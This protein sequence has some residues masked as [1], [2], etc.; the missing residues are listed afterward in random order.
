MSL[1]PNLTQSS[2]GD[3]NS[4]ARY[5]DGSRLG[6]PAVIQAGT[7]LSDSLAR[8]YQARLANALVTTLRSAQ[9]QWSVNWT[10]DA[11]EVEVP[12][13]VAPLSPLGQQ[14]FVFEIEKTLSVLARTASTVGQSIAQEAKEAIED[15]MKAIRLE[16]VF[17]HRLTGTD[18]FPEGAREL[19]KALK[20]PDESNYK[21][22]I[23][24]LVK[25]VKD[26]TEHEQPRTARQWETITRVLDDTFASAI[27][28]IPNS[29]LKTLV[30]EATSAER[31]KQRIL[32]DIFQYQ[33][34]NDKHVHITVFV[35]SLLFPGGQ[36]TTRAS[37]RVRADA[38]VNVPGAKESTTSQIGLAM[39]IDDEDAQV[40]FL[41]L[42]LSEIREAVLRHITREG[43]RKAREK[44]AESQTHIVDTLKGV[45]FKL[46]QTRASVATE[47]LTTIFLHAIDTLKRLRLQTSASF[48]GQHQHSYFRSLSVASR[49]MERAISLRGHENDTVKTIIE[50]LSSALNL[51]VSNIR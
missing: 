17:H 34:E 33:A 35:S 43:Q 44:I 1:Y 45:L 50:E 13:P 9:S 31:L 25:S 16:Q 20:S 7:F 4:S 10:S 46:Q 14:D 32:P 18:A 37:F 5:V 48:L 15:K 24:N 39:P 40:N 41:T 36:C 8:E 23:T 38:A 42:A 29:T 28:S 3:G 11:K 47:G 2:R 6:S 21:T 51:V 30:N 26:G 49:S 27:L 12:L 19:L 22:L